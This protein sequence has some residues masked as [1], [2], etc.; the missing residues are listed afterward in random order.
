[1]E[2]RTGEALLNP[3]GE[4]CAPRGQTAPTIEPSSALRGTIS[5]IWVDLRPPKSK[6]GPWDE[7]VK[8]LPHELIDRASAG[9]FPI[10][11]KS[12]PTIIAGAVTSSERRPRSSGEF[13]VPE[14]R[15]FTL[16]Q[17]QRHAC[18]FLQATRPLCASP[19]TRRAQR[20][21]SPLQSGRHRTGL[22][23]AA[24]LLPLPRW[25]D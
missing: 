9:S 16:G 19:R 14:I 8:L 25:P 20:G 24:A 18:A 23:R 6:P 1:M 21:P 11:L 15:G 22:S 17:R 2:D 3:E 5:G 4:V 13:R 7:T 10:E 12:L